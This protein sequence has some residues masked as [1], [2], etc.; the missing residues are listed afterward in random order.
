L[1]IFAGTLLGYTE[2][3]KLSVRVEHLES[4]LRF[5]SAAR[6]EVRYSAIP[7]AQVVE[8]HGTELRF[9]RECVKRCDDGESFAQA[10][11]NAVLSSGEN[12]G[13]AAHDA[14]LLLSFGEGF[15][16]SDTD[17]QISHMELYSGL[18][19]ANLK[20]ARDD[21]N[22]KSKLYLTLGV[23]AGLSSALLLC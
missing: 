11:K 2:S 3:H 22:R 5:L 9:L 15:G 18:F 4:F 19:R 23:F 14:E 1:L 10:W 12:D 6:T 13:F 7:V 8:R 16:T 21:R 20:S 17:G